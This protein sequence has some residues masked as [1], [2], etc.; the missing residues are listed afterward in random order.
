[1]ADM[2][3]NPK[4]LYCGS[5]SFLVKFQDKRQHYAE[6]KIRCDSVAGI[7]VAPGRNDKI[8]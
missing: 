2:G 1:M 3:Q 7:F 4:E 5:F 8:T 6:K